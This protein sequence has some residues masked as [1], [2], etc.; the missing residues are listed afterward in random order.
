M[1]KI[2]SLST[3][4]QWVHPGW[5]RAKFTTITT[6]GFGWWHS[7]RIFYEIFLH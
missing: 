3:Q 1:K 7:T 5:G 4:P 2:T 6:Y